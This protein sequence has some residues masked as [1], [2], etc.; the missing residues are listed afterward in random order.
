MKKLPQR[1]KGHKVIAK[2]FSNQ[3]INIVCN[4][5]GYIYFYLWDGVS[6]YYNHVLSFPKIK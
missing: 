2:Y 3:Y 4:S 5:K 6:D 1:M